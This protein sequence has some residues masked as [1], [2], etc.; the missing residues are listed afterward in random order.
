MEKKYDSFALPALGSVGSIGD[1]A[2]NLLGPI[3]SLFGGLF[4]GN[5]ATSTGVRWL[6]QQYKY[7]I[8]GDSSATSPTKGMTDDIAKQAQAV[9][10]AILG[11][12]IY[13]R[14]RLAALQG[15]DLGNDKALNNSDS[16]R[17]SNYLA[18]GPDTQGVDPSYVMQAVQIAKKLVHHQ[19]AGSWAPFAVQASKMAPQVSQYLPGAGGSVSN[20]PYVPGATNQTLGFFQRPQNKWMIYVGGALVLALIVFLIVKVAK[21]K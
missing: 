2:K 13:D 12:P 10:T 14:Y 11:V 18:L 21:K 7:Y 5:F 8:L 6:G 1:L 3:T 15:W 20:N 4:G 9:F 17:V 19:P 16:D